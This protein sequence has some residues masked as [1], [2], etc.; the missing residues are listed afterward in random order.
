[1]AKPRARNIDE[2]IIEVIL[3]IL[4]N[5]KGKL[6]WDSLI[7]AI[8]ASV[9]TKYT[10]QAL[11]KHERIAQAFS[12]RKRSLAKEQGRPEAKDA[13]TQGLLKTIETLKAENAR[14]Q[15]ECEGYRAKFIR[16]ASNAL[17]KNLTEQMLDAEL[18]RAPRKSTEEKIISLD[19]KKKVKSV[20]K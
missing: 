13:R 17:K 9:S 18:P 11:S 16:W 19:K 7:E 6:T 14:L 5:W 10:R 4:D 20:G 3:F 2:D 1:M 8:K 15:K 12:L